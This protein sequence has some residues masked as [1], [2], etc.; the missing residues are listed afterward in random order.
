MPLPPAS[1]PSQ[2]RISNE[3]AL[4]CIRVNEPDFTEQE[5][6]QLNLW[7][8][9][10]PAHQR[11][12]DAMLEIWTVCEHLPTDATGQGEPSPAAVWKS[13]LA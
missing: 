6:D 2:D 10:D 8:H 9:S 12:Y 4:W 7:L 11:E 3:A 5:R 13:L 1:E